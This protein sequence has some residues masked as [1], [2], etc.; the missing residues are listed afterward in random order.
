LRYYETAALSRSNRSNRSNRG[1]HRLA[2]VKSDDIDATFARLVFT[3]ESPSPCPALPQLTEK[4]TFLTLASLLFVRLKQKK[5]TERERERGRGGRK[6][7]RRI[8][9]RSFAL[10]P[11]RWLPR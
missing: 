2:R 10:S 4:D 9:K 1:W 7:G 5:G 3:I 8:S 11:F 6:K